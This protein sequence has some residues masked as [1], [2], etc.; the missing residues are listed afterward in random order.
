MFALPDI[1]GKHRFVDVPQ[2]KPS[3]V[4][5]D[6]TVERR[7]ALDEIRCETEFIDEEVARCLDV[8]N[9]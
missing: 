8:R 7:I 4:A 1:A 3:V 9:E 6:L 5:C 2:C